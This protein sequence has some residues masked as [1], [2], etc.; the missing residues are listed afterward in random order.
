MMQVQRKPYSAAEVEI[1]EF[2]FVY[3]ATEPPHIK[4]E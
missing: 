2:Q 4:V 1:D 3:S